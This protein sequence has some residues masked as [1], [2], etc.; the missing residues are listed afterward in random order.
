MKAG[1]IDSFVVQN[2]FK[3]GYE[4]IPDAQSQGFDMRVYLDACCLRTGSARGIQP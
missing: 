4:S 1:W 3:M 2:P